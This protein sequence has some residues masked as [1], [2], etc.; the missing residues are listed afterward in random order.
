[1]GQHLVDMSSDAYRYG[2]Y[3]GMV[4]DIVMTLI[5]GVGIA[6]R[7]SRGIQF[8]GGLASGV[9]SAVQG[10]WANAALSLAGSALQGMRAVRGGNSACR[11]MFN[12]ATANAI[13][14]T[15]Q[16][17]LQPSAS[18]AARSTACG[19]SSPATSWAA[20]SAC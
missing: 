10:D 9:E 16:R 15:A 12:N 20:A 2:T 5:P 13:A 8:A 11:P 14:N 19:K 18:A 3:A 17:G 4:A 1:M 7:N 6:S